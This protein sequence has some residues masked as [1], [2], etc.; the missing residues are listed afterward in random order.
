MRSI[1]SQSFWIISRGLKVFFYHNHRILKII[2]YRKQ[3]TLLL[4]VDPIRYIL[5]YYAGLS[6]PISQH[7][8][9][10][11]QYLHSHWWTTR[12]ESLKIKDAWTEIDLGVL[13]KAR[14]ITK[15]N[16]LNIR[17]TIYHVHKNY[18]NTATLLL[19][20]LYDRTIISQKS[21]AR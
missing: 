6:L 14:Y 10:T 12:S 18:M 21:I 9:S 1:K 19:H 3:P 11:I 2:F 8:F 5:V 20:K 17:T 13:R 16:H 4:I 15:I 7:E